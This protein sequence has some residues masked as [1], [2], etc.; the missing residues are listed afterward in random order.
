MIISEQY[1][2][3]SLYL[4][5]VSVASKGL[6]F[7]LPQSHDMAHHTPFTMSYK[8]STSGQPLGAANAEN[9]WYQHIQS[10]Y[11]LHPFYT[12]NARD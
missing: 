7:G 12:A 9:V 3:N 6:H 8:A 11:S 4:P 1:L 5:S 2:N 10:K